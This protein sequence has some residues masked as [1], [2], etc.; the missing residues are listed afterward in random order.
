MQLTDY[1]WSK[2]FEFSQKER[3]CFINNQK[4]RQLNWRHLS[5]EKVPKYRSIVNYPIYAC[6]LHM[7][8][9]FLIEAN[10][11]MGTNK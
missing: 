9:P 4:P 11:Q 7:L 6:S 5:T 1:K 10:G 2:K 8:I 3:E